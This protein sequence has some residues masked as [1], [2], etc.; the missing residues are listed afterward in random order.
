MIC[1]LCPFQYSLEPI[2]NSDTTVFCE[3]NNEPKDEN[4]ECFFPE[5]I[6]EKGV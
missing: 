1:R 4:D 6:M 3:I 2:D 5:T